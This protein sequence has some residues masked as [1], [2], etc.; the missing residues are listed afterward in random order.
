ML[1]ALVKTTVVEK[2]D[3]TTI[4]K[5]LLE[6]KPHDPFGRREIAAPCAPGHQHTHREGSNGFNSEVTCVLGWVRSLR[7]CRIEALFCELMREA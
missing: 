4:R 3:E 5:S 2:M 1:A 7:G 6:F